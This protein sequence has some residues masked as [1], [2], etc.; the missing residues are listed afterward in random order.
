VWMRTS[1]GVQGTY[2]LSIYDDADELAFR[3]DNNSR[4]R[5]LFASDLTLMDVHGEL[6]PSI[7]PKV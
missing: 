5:K 3:V 1:K 7:R 4:R 2:G 6:L